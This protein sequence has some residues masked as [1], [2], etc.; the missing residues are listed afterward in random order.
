MTDGNRRVP[1]RSIIIAPIYPR[2]S[3]ST[4]SRGQFGNLDLHRTPF[5]PPYAS[6]ADDK[7]IWQRATTVSIAGVTAH[8]PSATDFAA[9]AIAH[10]S[11]DAHKSSDWL[12]DMADSIDRGIDW[13]LF[14]Q[15]VGR[16][17]MQ[18]PAAVALGYVRVRLDRPVPESL[19]A[20]LEERA[21]RRPIALLGALSETRPK[22]DG[23]RIL[24]VDPC[25]HEAK[26]TTETPSKRA[27]RK[28]KPLCPAVALWR[29]RH[30]PGNRCQ[31]ARAAASL[32]GSQAWRGL[33]RV[34]RP[35]ALGRTPAGRPPGRFR[36]HL[37]QQTLPTP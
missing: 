34:D 9:I 6:I 16:R 2:P 21:I 17:R 14:E 32:A 22:A 13:I 24:L 4:S 8:V 12:A 20:R 37:E 28:T 11:L 23:C 27:R 5:H 19:L 25:N 33:E 31:S 26:P 36:D 18:A 3:A 1:E 29:P 35:H 10:G 15:D 30:E 7:G